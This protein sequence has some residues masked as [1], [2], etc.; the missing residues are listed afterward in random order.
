MLFGRAQWFPGEGFYRVE[1]NAVE[2]TGAPVRAVF[3]LNLPTP[4]PILQPNF[5]A[6][7]SCSGRITR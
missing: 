4:R 3:N 6:G 5:F 7:V 1:W 2:A